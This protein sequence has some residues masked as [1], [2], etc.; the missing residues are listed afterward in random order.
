[1]T[2]HNAYLEAGADI[3][4]TNT[5]SGTSI[6]QADYQTQELSYEINFS[7]ASI[8]RACA[9]AMSAKTPDKPRFVAGSMGPTNKSLSISPDIDN[10]AFRSLTFDEMAD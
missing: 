8:A 4:K 5:F 3:I 10:P 6:A 9:D 2:I 1:K 7:G